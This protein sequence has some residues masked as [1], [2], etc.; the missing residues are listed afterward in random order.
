ME[1]IKESGNVRLLS[2]GKRKQLFIGD[3][4]WMDSRKAEHHMHERPISTM[5][6]H[7][8]WIG[9]GIGLMFEL[10]AR[11]KNITQQSVLEINSD[12]IAVT[13]V[14]KDVTLY[15]GDAWV[16]EPPEGVVF[17]YIWTDITWGVGFKNGEREKLVKRFSKWARESVMSFPYG[18]VKA[19]GS[20][21]VA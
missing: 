18:K 21:K 2:D 4:L 9:L 5:S 12:V 10:A 19:E 20:A 8:L 13:D 3:D 15:K 7:V 11:N 17:D 1:L 16:W 6:G 14:P